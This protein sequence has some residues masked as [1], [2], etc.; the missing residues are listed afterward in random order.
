MEIKII[1]LRIDRSIKENESLKD[2]LSVYQKSDCLIFFPPKKEESDPSFQI[3]CFNFPLFLILRG[4]FKVNIDYDEEDP[5]NFFDLLIY[6]KEN[7]FYKILGENFD[8]N[9]FDLTDLENE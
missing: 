6:I 5:G 8:F 4:I 3:F 7:D 2:L 9:I 1:L